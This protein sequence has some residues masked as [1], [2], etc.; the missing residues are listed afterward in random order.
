M[1]DIKTCCIDSRRSAIDSTYMGNDE[2]ILD[3]IDD[4]FKR[5]EEFAKD[6]NDVADFE[7]KFQSSPLSQEYTSLFTKIM[8]GE[9]DTKSQVGDVFKDAAED[10]VD[11][12]SLRARR[13]TREQVESGLRNTPIVGDVMTAKQHFDFFSRFKKK[14]DEEE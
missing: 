11:S 13:E 12:V 6:C 8:G 3:M 1:N 5:L 10:V 7:A 4:F 2:K 14:K 9:V